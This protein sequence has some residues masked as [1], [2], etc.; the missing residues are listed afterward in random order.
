MSKTE[1]SSEISVLPI[2][3]FLITFLA[4]KTDVICQTLKRTYADA[5]V[6][7]APLGACTAI[8]AERGAAS[9]MTHVWPDGR[10]WFVA[11][12]MIFDNRT[13]RALEPSALADAFFGDA[14]DINRFEG[15]FAAV[16]HDS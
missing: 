7:V 14:P 2:G 16:I 3:H 13:E 8:V 12:G 10:G 9:I 11:K 5:T 4:T 6:E 1:Q 15:E